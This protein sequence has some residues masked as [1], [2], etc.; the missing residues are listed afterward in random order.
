MSPSVPDPTAALGERLLQAHLGLESSSEAL[1]D[2]MVLTV[3]KEIIEGRIPPGA[4]VDS[5]SLSKRFSSS[6][7]P[8]REALIALERHGLLEIEPR[9]RPRV[10][11]LSGEQVIEIYEL[12]AVLHGL[13][14]QKVASR[15]TEHDLESLQASIHQ[16]HEAGEAGDVNTYFW[17]QV[18]FHDKAA[19][20]ARDSTLKRVTY[21]LGLQ[22]LRVRRTGMGLPGRLPRS[23]ADHERLLVAYRESDADLAYALGRSLV[24]DALTLLRREDRI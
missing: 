24:L 14:A 21:G 8:V 10:S 1:V 15:R 6:R 12:R 13:I 9:R 4:V 5:L 11:T 19:D 17:S 7:T 23:L 2:H 22:V 3:A 16:M 20:I 18:E